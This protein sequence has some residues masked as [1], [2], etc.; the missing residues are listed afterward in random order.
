M[1]EVYLALG[2][3]MGDSAANI[4]KAVELLREKINDIRTAP[5]YRSKPLGYT[6]QPDF[7]NTALSG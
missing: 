7:L 5:V 6:D 4:D 2:S 3:N 1:T